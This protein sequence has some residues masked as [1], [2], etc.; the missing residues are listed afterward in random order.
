MVSTL[1]VFIKIALDV[2]VVHYRQGLF[3]VQNPKTKTTPKPNKVG[4]VHKTKT[5]TNIKVGHACR[6]RG[7]CRFKVGSLRLPENGR[8]QDLQQKLDNVDQAVEN[9]VRLKE[10]GDSI[11]L[12]VLHKV[13]VEGRGK[14]SFYLTASETENPVFFQI[15]PLLTQS[16][17]SYRKR[18]LTT[19]RWIIKTYRLYS[20]TQIEI[21]IG[22]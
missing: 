22:V 18:Y 10:F 11:C 3:C 19:A 17:H 9:L 21:F 12:E 7:L 1:R 20:N 16:V 2:V 6:N 13:V 14:I 5:K 15:P 4:H 8:A